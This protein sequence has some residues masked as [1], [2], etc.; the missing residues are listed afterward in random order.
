MTNEPFCRTRLI[1]SF[2]YILRNVFYWSRRVIVHL[3]HTLDHITSLKYVAFEWVFHR[4]QGYCDFN[5][6]TKEHLSQT[7]LIVSLPYI[8]M[9]VF[10]QQL[11]LAPNTE[12]LHTSITLKKHQKKNRLRLPTDG[13]WR[14]HGELGNTEL[15][16]TLSSIRRFVPQCINRLELP[17]SRSG[18]VRHGRSR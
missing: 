12:M 17:W 14:F 2:S 3:S 7:R 5:I 15:L 11:S 1:V 13:T 16:V 6:T 18:V 9:N 8:M 10:Y 4:N